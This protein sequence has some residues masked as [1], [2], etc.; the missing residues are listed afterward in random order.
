VP[1]TLSQRAKDLIG[2]DVYNDLKLRS[3]RLFVMDHRPLA[4]TTVN[5]LDTVVKVSERKKEMK[6]LGQ[7]DLN[8][9]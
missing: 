7:W 9:V 6:L 5:L 8:I 4:P 3:Q 2:S 1:S